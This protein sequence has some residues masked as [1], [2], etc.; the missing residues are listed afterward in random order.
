MNEA[1]RFI[2]LYL[3]PR[4]SIPPS[5]FPNSAVPS[6]PL[7]TLPLTHTP[8]IILLAALLFTATLVYSKKNPDPEAQNLLFRPL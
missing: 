5:S 1:A 4:E 6:R 3:F 2:Y 8:C 7:L